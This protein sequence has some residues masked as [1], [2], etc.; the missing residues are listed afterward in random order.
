MK[1]LLICMLFVF[2]FSGCKDKN[3]F[4]YEKEFEMLATSYYTKYQ[5]GQGLN[6]A[7]VYLKDLKEA[8][9]KMEDTFDLSKLEKCDDDSVVRIYLKSGTMQIEKYEFELKCS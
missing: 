4:D 7:E 2:C 5:K 3:T 6:I 8:N 9:E 1:K